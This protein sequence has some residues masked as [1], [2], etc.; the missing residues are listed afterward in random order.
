MQCVPTILC[1]SVI[2]TTRY[3]AIPVRSGPHL[4]CPRAA[5]RIQPPFTASAA[6]EMTEATP[7]VWSACPRP[8]ASS[9]KHTHA[10]TTDRPQRANV[11]IGTRGAFISAWR[12]YHIQ[13]PRGARSPARRAHTWGREEVLGVIGRVMFNSW[14]QAVSR[15]L[16]MRPFSGKAAHSREFYLLKLTDIRPHHV[17]R[18]H[19]LD[20]PSC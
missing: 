14:Q 10:H 11:R 16:L 7:L 9:R 17:C 8:S 2:L 4:V 18:M 6:P 20:H 15:G 12:A 5:R 13:L 1:R 19:A 3:P